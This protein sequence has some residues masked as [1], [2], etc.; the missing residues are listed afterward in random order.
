MPALRTGSDSRSSPR[1]QFQGDS[2]SF[3]FH[4]RRRGGIAL[5]S[6]AI[7]SCGG[8]DNTAVTPVTATP[9][10]SV[11]GG[12]Y[13]ASQTVSLSDTTSGA[14][15]YYTLDG[16]TPATTVGGSTLQY[17]SAL[18]VT[19]STII[20]AVALAPSHSASAL[21]G[22]AYTIGPAALAAGIWAG[23]DSEATPEDVIGIVTASGQSVFIRTGTDDQ[24]VSV[25]SGPVTVTGTTTFTSTLDGFSDFPYGF[26]DNSTSGVGSFD[27]TLSARTSLTGPLA[28]T[29]VGGTSYPG[30]WTLGYSSV[31][32]TGSSL[33]DVAATYTDTSTQADPIVGATITFSATGVISSTV[34]TSGCSM[35]G[36]ISTADPTTDIYEISFTL[37]GC[38]GTW[39]DLNN[40][41]FSGLAVLNNSVSPMQLVLGVNGQ[42]AANAQYGLAFGFNQG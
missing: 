6:L 20:E 22:A 40:V 34:A 11:A 36:A 38:G 10:F 23:A 19:S 42:G 17:S 4:L 7:A 3:A 1:H 35:N 15:I 18:T 25:F 26:A 37:T 41:L 16:T 33:A 9:T 14:V 27:A 21:T 32:L 13:T 8:H 24:E 5:L 30:T 39:A 31:S 2:M 29:S 28:F 12:P